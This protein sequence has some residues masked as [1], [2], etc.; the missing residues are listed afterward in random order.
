MTLLAFPLK[1]EREAHGE[2][3]TTSC[4]IWRKKLFGELSQVAI[5]KSAGYLIT[6]A[7][8]K[9]P[10]FC[11]LCSKM[12]WLAWEKTSNILGWTASLF[13]RVILWPMCSLFKVKIIF[14]TCKKRTFCFHFKKENGGLV[15]QNDLGHAIKTVKMPLRQLVFFVVFKPRVRLLQ[16]L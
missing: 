6:H 16:L 8:K 1:R 3:T 11:E 13:F 5:A 12:T 10:I 14:K 2:R 7:H 4:C 9:Y 15:F